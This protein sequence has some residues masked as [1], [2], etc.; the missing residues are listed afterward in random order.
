MNARV[1][2][3]EFVLGQRRRVLWEFV[4]ERRGIDPG[5]I[6]DLAEVDW[7]RWCATSSDYYVTDTGREQLPRE[8]Q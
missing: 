2:T 4:N 5:D 7:I 3:Q 6:E 8:G 1:K